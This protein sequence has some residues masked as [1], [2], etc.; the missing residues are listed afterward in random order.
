[1]VKT[2]AV[3]VLATL[4]RQGD[5]LDKA[6]G[7]EETVALTNL[8]IIPVTKSVIESGTIVIKGGKIVAVGAEI[9]PPAGARI[10]EGRGL[11][12]FPGLVHPYS[13]LGLPDGLSAV[14][15]TPQHLAF[16]EINPTADAIAQAARSGV[17]TFVLQPLGSGIAG[18]AAALKPAGWTRE[19]QVIEKSAA[20][21]LQ[22]LPGTAGKE[23]LRQALEGAKKAVEGEK[24]TPPAKPDDKTAVLAKFLKGE[25]PGFV[26][27]PGPGELL[28]FWQVMEPFAEFKPRLTFV[29]GP[30]IY[31]AAAELGSR[32]ARV[33][34]RPMVALAPFTRERIN[35][36]A[37]LVTAGVEVAFAPMS[38]APEALQ[39]CLF[40]V[41][42]LVKFGLPREAALRAVTIVPAG[43]AGLDKRIGSIEAGKDA[44]LLLF[45]GDPLSPQSRLREVYITGTSVYRGE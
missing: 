26:E 33:I 18:Q 45:S 16:D 10:V 21:R 31:K 19:E 41:A 22:L 35:T 14:G 23:A 7:E 11:V 2:L 29:A 36:A 43:M 32:K 40:R 1:V 9:K 30:E 6:R 27:V 44:D 34:L 4:L 12:A 3:L 5:P 28:H 17:T 25:L 38:D 20:L 15:V 13:R 37:E 42:E 24:K 8:R 39:G